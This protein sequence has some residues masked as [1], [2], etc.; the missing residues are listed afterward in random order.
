[1]LLKAAASAAALFLKLNYDISKRYFLL[2]MIAVSFVKCTAQ[3]NAGNNNTENSRL[4][5]PVLKVMVNM[6]PEEEEEKFS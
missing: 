6:Q 2:A 5:F 1:M 3:K 4:H